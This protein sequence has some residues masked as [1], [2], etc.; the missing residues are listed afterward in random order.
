MSIRLAL[1]AL[2]VA[3]LDGATITTLDWPPYVSRDL[4]SG[5]FVTAVVSA[6]FAASGHED[7]D[8]RTYPW[9]RAVTTARTGSAVAYFPEY[10]SSALESDFRFSAPMPGG[11]IAFFQRIGYGFA[12]NGEVDSLIGHRLGVVRGYVNTEAIDTHAGLSRDLAID[13][14]TNLRKLAGKRIDLAIIDPLVADHL[15]AQPDLARLVGQVEAVAPVI[16]FKPL[17]VCFSRRHPEAE[18]Y[19]AAFDKGLQAIS[20]DGRLDAILTEFGVH[21]RVGLVDAP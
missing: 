5:G 1:L 16:E 18:A 2:L 19:Q 10:H 21:G 14:A 4:P 13:D 7:V 6:A 3:H 17:H 11:P 15:L 9:E 8:I 12:W 20:E